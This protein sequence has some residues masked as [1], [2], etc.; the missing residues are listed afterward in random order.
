MP[1]YGATTMPA[2]NRLTHCRSKCVRF[3]RGGQ[4]FPSAS[5]AYAGCI[6][7]GRAPDPE[8]LQSGMFFH[9]RSHVLRPSRGDHPDV[10]MLYREELEQRRRRGIVTLY[11]AFFRTPEDE[12]FGC[13][14]DETSDQLPE[15]EHKGR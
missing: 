10:D 6:F 7:P 14:D 13:S 9:A 15:M 4:P 3:N 2:E 8:R 12:T 11:P 1:V 5:A